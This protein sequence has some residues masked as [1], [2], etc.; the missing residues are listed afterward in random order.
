VSRRSGQPSS[1][2]IRE[3]WRSVLSWMRWR[4]RRATRLRLEQEEQQHQLLLLM[5][6]Q[7]RALLLEAL[8]P[9]AEAMKRL[10]QRILASQMQQ[11]EHQQ[12]LRELLMEVLQ[13]QVPPISQQLGLSTPPQLP[14][15]WVS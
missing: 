11:V 5:E 6:H 7:Q 15:S 12:E 1:S 3:T 10:D 9:V 8:T 13:S 4:Q 14:P 2:R